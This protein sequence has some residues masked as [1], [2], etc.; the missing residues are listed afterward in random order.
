MELLSWLAGILRILK[1]LLAKRL[2]LPSCFGSCF[3]PSL[4]WRERILP[5]TQHGEKDAVTM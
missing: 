2:G 3:G 5:V 1:R 4:M